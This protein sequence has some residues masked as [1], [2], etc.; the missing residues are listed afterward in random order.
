MS[1]IGKAA[2]FAMWAHA[3]Q[4]RKYRGEPYIVHCAEV[5]GLVQHVAWEEVDDAVAAAWLHDTIEDR[6]D[7]ANYALIGYLFNERVQELVWALTDREDGNRDTRKALQR[8]RLSSAPDIAKTIKLADLI[9]NTR[10][11]VADD[12][13]FAKTYMAEKRLLL[14]VLSG[15]SSL[16]WNEANNQVEAYF[17]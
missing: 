14:P 17:A 11:I 7:R 12:P 1:I 16:L 9:S 8:A 15:G 2:E 6:P 13:N 4:K 3:G 10:S 5:A